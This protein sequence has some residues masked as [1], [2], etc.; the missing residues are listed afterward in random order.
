MGWNYGGNSSRSALQLHQLAQQMAHVLPARQW[1]IV[2][3]LFDAAAHADG[4]FLFDASVAYRYAEVFR[5][6]AAHPKMPADGGQFALDI[7]DHASAA[8]RSGRLWRWS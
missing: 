3:G 6:A 7:A 4:P 5:A 1:R 2:Q 8:I